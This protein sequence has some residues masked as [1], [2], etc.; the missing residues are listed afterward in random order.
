MAANWVLLALL[1]S[2]CLA[3]SYGKRSG[4]SAMDD[5]VKKDLLWSSSGSVYKH[6]SSPSVNR[7]PTDLP[8]PVYERSPY[9]GSCDSVDIIGGGCNYGCGTCDK[10][11]GYEVGYLEGL[12][13]TI[14][15]LTMKLDANGLLGQKKGKNMQAMAPDSS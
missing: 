11:Y 13:Q 6:G 12:K 4:V 8:S 1:L 7:D 5:I 15:E 10:D 2:L 9:C 14:G 3:T